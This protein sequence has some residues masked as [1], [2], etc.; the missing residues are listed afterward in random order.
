MKK[1]LL[2]LTLPIALAAC[3]ST[4][5]Q[6]THQ[7]ATNSPKASAPLPTGDTAETSLDWSGVYKG[8]FP[9]ADCEG[10]ETT[11]TLKQDKTYVLQER[12]VK[13]GK[14]AHNAKASGK[15][16][17]NRAKP[18]LIRLDKQANQRV[19]FIGEGFV[20]ARDQETGAVISNNLNY[21][22]KQVSK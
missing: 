14:T 4:D 5:A 21:K 11:L 15:F 19:F 17:F 1:I 16:E 22:L 12:Y 6:P 7:A 10:I 20:E 2:L 9:C 18:S 8:V 3:Q 13:N